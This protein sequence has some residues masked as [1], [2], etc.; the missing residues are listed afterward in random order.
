AIGMARKRQGGD[1][2]ADV[3]RNRAAIVD[4]AMRQL[5]HSPV[6]EMRRLAAEA[7]VSRSTLYRRFGGADAVRRAVLDRT[8]AEAREAVQ[9]AVAAD[10]A[11]L[12]L[13]RR[14]VTALIAAGAR[15]PLPEV[16]E[17]TLGEQTE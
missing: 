2:R 6:L 1:P 17:S 15:Y 11:P 16:V 10:A 13:L 8:L 4:A 14:A 7:S 12:A 5:A 9:A 3:E